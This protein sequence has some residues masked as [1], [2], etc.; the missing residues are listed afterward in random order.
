MLNILYGVTLRQLARAQERYVTTVECAREE[1]D[2]ALA[3][4][5]V[6]ME[7]A[8][9]NRRETFLAAHADGMSI[10]QIAAAVNLSPSRVSQV[11]RGE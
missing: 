9:E 6:R 11:L 10:R 3:E 2:R 4:Y 5:K 8:R 1:R 7:R